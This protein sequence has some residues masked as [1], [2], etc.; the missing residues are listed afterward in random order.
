M[1]VK[2]AIK[3]FTEDTGIFHSTQSK[4][5]SYC[6]GMSKITI[7][8]ETKADAAVKYN[9]LKFEEFLEMIGRV[10]HL[11]YNLQEHAEI[12]LSQKIEFILDEIL[13]VVKEKRND[14]EIYIEDESESDKDY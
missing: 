11:K 5:V 3:L 6:F 9:S 1:T 12:T 4:N 10:A 8:N 13:A 2:D 14:P 7:I